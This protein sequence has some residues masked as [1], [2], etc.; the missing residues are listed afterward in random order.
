MD[1]IIGIELYPL[2]SLGIFFLF[3][4]ALLWWTIRADKDYI[5]ASAA[6][7]LSDSDTVKPELL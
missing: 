1:T 6:M 4:I 5:N 7:P 2:I 3:F